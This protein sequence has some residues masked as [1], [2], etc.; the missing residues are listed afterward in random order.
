MSRAFRSSAAFKT[1]LDLS[2]LIAPASVATDLR[3]LLQAAADIDLGD[4]VTFRIGELK[5][6]L[7]NAP[8][9]GG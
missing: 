9:G 7:T 8:A 5:S 4:Y 1:S 3:D 2:V 6:E